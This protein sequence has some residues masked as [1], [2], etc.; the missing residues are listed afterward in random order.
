MDDLMQNIRQ[1]LHSICLGFLELGK[2]ETYVIK[3]KTII[4]FWVVGIC[5]V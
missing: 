4:M 3:E 1:E 5:E 2:A